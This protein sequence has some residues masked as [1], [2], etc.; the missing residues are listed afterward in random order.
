MTHALPQR[1]LGPLSVSALGLGCMGMS[2]FYGRADDQRS[3]AAIH[4][5][6]DLGITLLDTADAYGPLTN[7]E[8]VG[9]AIR[10]RRH[11]VVVATKFGHMRTSEG[12]W[13][14]IN[15]RPE[16][17]RQAC[18][19]SLKR[20]GIDTIDLYY[21]HRVDAKTPIEDTVGA[22]AELVHAG[23]VRHLGLSEAAPET[24]RRAYAVY[25]IAALQTE[26]SLWTRGPEGELL[27]TCRALN[28]GFV[29]YSPLGRGLLT[30]QIR[31]IDDLAAD[32][33]RRANPRFQGN[34][35]ERNRRLVS[36]VEEV[37]HRN[38]C[39]AAQVALS[40]LLSRGEDIV[41]IPGSTRFERI[42]ENTRALEVVLA[43]DD[44]Q[45]LDSLGQTVA[46]DRYAEGG[47]KTVNR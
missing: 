18:D 19:A 1:R 34:N 16:Y 39:T 43:P 30:G 26:Y 22:M 15:G 11:R 5:T 31:S 12:A 47:M 3:I 7:E 35:F 14:G 6:L 33:W 37:A 27:E 38:G 42:E 25:P 46:G 40:W 32:D 45:A 9:R 29:A 13:Q 24:L 20:L 4:K 44:L 41:P 2:E 10:D 17:V 36:V 8:L 23:K 28:V 21:Q